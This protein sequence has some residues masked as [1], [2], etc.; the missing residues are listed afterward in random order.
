V[1]LTAGI[2]AHEASCPPLPMP[3]WSSA[4]YTQGQHYP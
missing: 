4:S 2:K 1:Q 3:S